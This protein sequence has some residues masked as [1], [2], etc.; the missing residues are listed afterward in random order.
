MSELIT[1]QLIDH[2]VP[3]LPLERQHVVMCTED[4]LRARGRTDLASEH[5]FVNKI[6]DSLEVCCFFLYFI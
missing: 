3:F 5:D 1:S 4:Y 2:F 6:V